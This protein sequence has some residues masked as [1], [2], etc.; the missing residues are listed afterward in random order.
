[1]ACLAETDLLSGE[2]AQ[3]W[4][5]FD[6]HESRQSIGSFVLSGLDCFELDFD[7]ER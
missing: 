2:I 6:V 3:H 4:I 1:L 7:R 5:F